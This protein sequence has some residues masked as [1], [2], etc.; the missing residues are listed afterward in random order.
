[1]DEEKNLSKEEMLEVLQN[2]IDNYEN[3]PAQ[4]MLTTVNQYDFC[5]LLMIIKA[6]VKYDDKK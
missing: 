4:A 2:M 1:M 6:Y 3:L 5:S